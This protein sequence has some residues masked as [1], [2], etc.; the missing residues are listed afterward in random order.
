MRTLIRSRKRARANTF[1]IL[2]ILVWLAVFAV[3]LFIV[4][5][6]GLSEGEEVW[7]ILVGQGVPLAILMALLWWVT[8]VEKVLY[9]FNQIL[10]LGTAFVLTL[11][12]CL[13]GGIASPYFMPVAYLGMLIAMTQG[14]TVAVTAHT[15]LVLVS[16][17]MGGWGI[18]AAVPLYVGGMAGIYLVSTLRQRYALL[19][20]GLLVGAL[21]ALIAVMFH[22]YQQSPAASMIG[23]ALWCL[24]GGTLSAV[25]LLG[26]LPVWE[27]L[28]GMLTPYKLMELADPNQ[29]LLKRLLTEAPGTYHHSVMVANLAESAAEALGADALL[30]RVG[31]YYHDIGKLNAPGL[32]KENQS[33]DNPH[34]QLRP[35]ESAQKILNHVRDGL[36]LARQRRLP[37][38][39]RA[40]IAEHHGTTLV[41]YFYHKACEQDPA[42]DEIKFR[43]PGPL[44]QTRE[45]AIV[46]L[47]DAVESA[48]RS[49]RDAG[50]EHIQETVVSIMDERMRSGQLDQCALTVAEVRRMQGLFMNALKSLYHERVEYPRKPEAAI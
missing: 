50:W 1:S 41:A 31:S 40:F 43:Y 10:M 37:E 17:M 24:A 11:A 32:F 35:G 19:L 4:C 48:A 23:E 28:F 7:A 8:A 9:D 27:N 44:P 2:G 49:M 15:V 33:G 30:A 39:I 13:A 6:K 5:S 22:L 16:V 26:T 3:S 42:V 21:Q 46:M 36:T 38:A 29:Q 18:E 25:L 14:R 34:D 20:I 47:A 45:S 12:L